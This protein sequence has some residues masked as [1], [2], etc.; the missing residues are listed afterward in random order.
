MWFLLACSDYNF[1]TK[2]GAGGPGEPDIDV[3]PPILTF[4]SAYLG[5]EESQS[6]DV[7]NRGD[8]L[9][10]IDGLRMVSDTFRAELGELYLEPG[11]SVQVPVSWLPS[12]AGLATAE[13]IIDSNDPDEE[14]SL[15]DLRG[16]ADDSV[17]MTDHFEQAQT[18]IDVLWVIDNSSSMAEE[19]SRVAAGIASFFEYFVT[20]GL[21][22]HMGVITSDVVNPLMQGRLQGS[23]AWLSPDTPNAAVELAEAVNV[24]TEDQGDESGL[25]AA[26][27]ALSEP[28]LSAENAGF[29]RPD[30]RL[31][32]IFVT[33]EPEWSTYDAAYFID[34]F[35]ALKLDP[36]YLLIS[37]IVGDRGSGCST[38]CDGLPQTAQPSDKYL[39]VIEYFGGTFASICTCDLLPALDALGDANTIWFRTVTLSQVPTQSTGIS[40][41]VAGVATTA[42]TYD[43][44]TNTLTFDE[45]PPEGAAIDVTY[46]V[47]PTCD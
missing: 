15:V 12:V 33:D 8:V 47:T 16:Q 35:S 34:F 23:P 32:L 42:W 30:A 11:E 6:I 24:G 7:E 2:G 36:S 45:P 44:S 3:D 31:A 27:M 28:V 17:L 20:L 13:L 9:L 5:C 37:G 39:D 4:E 14:H 41:T 25:L 38:T 40:V 43:R 26:Y 22:Y 19:Q 1:G 18:D 46:P 29:Y 10:E 21:D